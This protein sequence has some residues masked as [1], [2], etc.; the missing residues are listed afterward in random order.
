MGG[1]FGASNTPTNAPI[2]YSGL[3]VG[4]SQWNLPVPLFWGTR[5]LST[6]AMAYTN[7]QK[8][9]Q[10]GGKGGGGKGG[11]GKGSQSYT[12]T[13]DVLLGLCEG[14]VDS[15]VNIWAN[16]ST[17]T[18][19]SLSALN[20]TFFNGA[21]GQSPWSY[22][23]TNYP[24]LM[25][26]YSQTA[27]LGA[28]NLDLGSSAS[29][30]DIAFECVRASMFSWSR[31]GTAAGWKNPNT[32]VQSSATDVLMSDVI[33]DFL[34]NPQYKADWSNDDIGSLTQYGAYLRAQG[35]FASPLIN[36]QDKATSILNRWAQVTNSWIFWSG[37][38]LECFPLA[39]APITGNGVTFTPDNDVAYVL[40][41]DDLIAAK[42]E[43]PVKVNRKDPADCFNRVSVEICDRTLGYISNPIPW[44]DDPLVDRY[45]NRNNTSISAG[46]ICD[47]EVGRILAQLIGKRAAYIRNTYQF[48]TTWKFIRCL[49]GTVLMIPLNFSGL[50]I[51]V[52]VTE[53]AENEAGELQIMA[54]EFPGTAATYVPMQVTPAIGTSDVPNEYAPPASVNTPAI[55]E[56]PASFT[57][58]VA[59]IIIAASG[60]SNWGGCRVWL[61]FDG[62]SYVV[63]GEITAP[64][65]Q[66]V[67]TAS[68]ASFAGP[69]PDTGHTLA[70]DC[71]Q[72][73]T[74]PQPV[75]N[76]DAQNLRT[77]SLVAPQPTVSGGA[78]IVP[79]NGELLAFGNVV[80]TG[81]YSANLTY[82][83]RGQYGTTA[84]SHAAG[85]QFTL[86]DVLGNSGTSIAFDLPA[87]YIG[88][89][90]YLKFSSY[91]A[92]GNAAQD[93]SACTEY[94]YIPTGAGYG[95]GTDGAPATPT[96]LS[97]VGGPA[98]AAVV[99]NANALA[100]NV[101]TYRLFR[102]DGAGADF[103]D[104]SL[105]FQGLAYTY[106]DTTCA[107]E[108]DYTYFVAASNLVGTS[109][110]SAGVSVTTLSNG[111]ITSANFVFNEPVGGTANGTNTVFTLATTPLTGQV[112][113]TVNGSVQSPSTYTLSGSTITF[114][115]APP[116]GAVLLATY[117]T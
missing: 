113:L 84:R 75:T 1:I 92:F 100:D 80:A 96:G 74:T 46:D 87:Q 77:L 11:G 32:H 28:P 39:D 35:I 78:A 68:L 34:T 106:T 91:N 63:A 24:S 107:P 112:S 72:S 9:S 111:T 10:S 16:G 45:G 65:P 31:T 40:T 20:M 97:A 56:P 48:K 104:A 47:P 18:T 6:N 64:A 41:L 86:I 117:L 29:V 90:L 95:T 99:W 60:D 57:G 109:S 2:I 38:R 83:E 114:G 23:L 116:S 3:N 43:P 50:N 44:T 22:W 66:G 33:R 49:P 51:R 81:T 5:R 108:T 36:A 102:A 59:K 62:S 53:I 54:E 52:R 42:D 19:T 25:Q 89:P 79:T 105:V 37:T 14:P 94:L 13:A 115:T 71:A 15:I 67:L 26:G 17:T 98:S 4:T 93:L 69:N 61:S 85:E 7:F 27:Y 70:V 76:A 88:Q 21:L 55:F 12:Y 101:I 58:N 110:P 8:H 82:L 73:R 30:P 103:A